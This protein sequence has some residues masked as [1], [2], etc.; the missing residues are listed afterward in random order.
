MVNALMLLQY[1]SKYAYACTNSMSMQ[2]TCNCPKFHSP[3]LGQRG[4]SL[5]HFDVTRLRSPI[6]QRTPA[7]ASRPSVPGSSLLQIAQASSCNHQIINSTISLIN[8]TSN[9]SSPHQP[10][11][12]HHDHNRHH[13]PCRRH[14]FSHHPQ[15]PPLLCGMTSPQTCC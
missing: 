2:F 7:I 4:S 9:P 1:A 6:R 11:P 8:L 15:R 12:T 14:R 3:R 5:P 13:V 10:I